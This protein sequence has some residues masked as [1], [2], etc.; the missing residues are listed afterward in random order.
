MKIC[1]QGLW[2]LGTITAACLA[3]AG[4]HVVGLDFDSRTV[5]RLREGIPPLFEPGLEALVQKG[6]SAGNLSFT[7]DIHEAVEGVD[8]LWI[9]YDTP[10]DDDDKA[11]VPFVLERVKQTLPH[12]KGHP[13]VLISSQ[14]PAGSTRSLESPNASFA[15]SPENLRLG[16]AIAAFTQPERVIVGIRNKRDREL[17]EQLF[18]A[19]TSRIE[20]MSVESAEMTKHALN[21]FLATSVSFINEIA[22]ICEQVGADA[23]E[24]ERGLKS[25]ARIGPKA[26]LS[27]GG[28]FAGGTLARDIAF[29]TDIGQAKGVPTDLLSGV[30]TSNNKHR[31]W[32]RRRLQTV[33]GDLKGKTVAVW[34]LTYKPGTDTLRRSS[35]IEL[36]E[37]LYESGARVQAF[38]PA[39]KTVPFSLAE[40]IHLFETPLAA[41]KDAHALVVATESPEFSSIDGGSIVT[42]M[43]A[44]LVFDAARFLSKELE[45]QAGLRYFAVGKS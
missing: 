23:K 14:L 29:L 34:G 18:S 40:R 16:K 22:A 15:Y 17:L 44:A 39:V 19:F 1:V 11:D 25:E 33:L 41:L 27:P 7:T 35:A 8:I 36:C 31:Q 12:L 10:V 26:Y 43:R 21:A 45:S 13:L 42:A 3:T 5:E 6:L 37:W 2:H 24:V 4:H 30:R 9:A 38:D 28:A 20:F 32:A